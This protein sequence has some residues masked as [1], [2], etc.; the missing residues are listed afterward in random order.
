MNF[1]AN[2]R[3]HCTTFFCYNSLEDNARSPLFNKTM[4]QATH[5]KAICACML[6]WNKMHGQS[7]L[8]PTAVS[9]TMFRIDLKHQFGDR[10]ILANELK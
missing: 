9:S 1:V 8:N 10:S 7:F 4:L 5:N 3:Y 6:G 2:V